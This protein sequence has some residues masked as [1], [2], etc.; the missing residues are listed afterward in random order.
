MPA[1]VAGKTHSLGVEDGVCDSVEAS[2][3]STWAM[4]P[5]DGRGKPMGLGLENLTNVGLL[6]R[7]LC[8]R[9]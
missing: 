6:I 4:I 9:V 5:Q 7:V 1:E 2:I 3:H 8:F